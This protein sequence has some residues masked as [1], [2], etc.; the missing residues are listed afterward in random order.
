MIPRML[1]TVFTAVLILLF[2][3]TGGSK[4][5]DM[6]EFSRQ[7]QLQPL[8]PFFKKIFT[9]AVPVVELA[10]CVLLLFRQM[11]IYG[12]VLSFILMLSFTIYVALI[13]ASSFQFIPCSCAGIYNRMSWKT[14]LY[15]NGVY[16]VIALVALILSWNERKQTEQKI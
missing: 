16:T 5:L 4:L 12:L 8:S 3:Y 7:M 13:L 9:V 15:V 6:T 1:I 11:K 10:A 14:H 2:A